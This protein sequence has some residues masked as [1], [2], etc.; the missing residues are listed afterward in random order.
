M[1]SES[2]TVARRLSKAGCA[3]LLVLPASLAMGAP[4]LAQSVINTSVTS[5]VSLDGQA[6]QVEIAAGVS[7]NASG[8]AAVSA[9]LPAQLSNNGQVVDSTGIGIALS[10]GGTVANGGVVSAGS[11]GVRVTGAG[12][13]VSNNGQ[14][15]A[16]YDG[17]S[18]NQGGSV[19]NSGSIFGGHIGVYTGNGL[20]V[21]QNSG[22][23][24]ARSGDAVSLYSGGT[25]T[26]TASGA[27]LGGYSG[28]YAGGNGASISNAGLISGPL[29]GV[30][31]MGDSTITNSGTIAGGTAGVIDIGRGGTVVNSGVIHGGKAGLQFAAGGGLD[32]AG[33]ISGGVDGVKLGKTGT[34]TNEAGGGITGGGVGV[35]AG[36]GDVILNQG[37]ITG[38]TGLQVNGAAS[39]E[40]AGIIA[41]SAGGD[42]ISLGGGAS[43]ITLDTGAEIDGDIAGNGTASFVSLTGH[44]SLAASI[45]GFQAGQLTVQQNA[46]W[47][48][49]G[50]WAVGQVVN[51]GTLTA[52]LVG[53]PLTITGDFTQTSTGTLRVVATPQGMNHLI[54]S[55]TAHLAG[56]L[57]YVLSP[58]TYAPASYKF[59]T[60]SAIS[61]DFATVETSDAAQ[62]S[63]LPGGSAAPATT[64]S[65]TVA[66]TPAAPSGG[67]AP[68]G[69]STVSAALSITQ[70]LVVVPK[71]GGLFADA[72]QAMALAGHA[73]G[74][75]LLAAGQ[76]AGRGGCSGPAPQTVGQAGNV[77]AALAD[78]LCRMGGWLQVTGSDLSTDGVYDARGGGFLAGLDRIV[79]A[80]RIGL[81]VGFDSAS[82]KDEAGGQASLQT[83]RLGLYG[84]L[85]AGP[86]VL[87]AALMDGLVTTTS[88]RATGAGGGAAS[89]NGNVLSA[90]LQAALPVSAWGAALR[91]AAGLEITR[92]SLGALSES[93][94][95]QALAVR[96]QA[97][98]GVYVAPYLRLSVSRRF[99][100]ARGLEIVPDAMLG[101]TV[102]ATNPGVSVA[103]TAR[104]GTAFIAAPLHLSPVSGEAGLGLS[105]GHGNW[106]LSARYDAILA[107]SFHAQS[108][109]ASL[110]VRF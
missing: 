62:H 82:L 96:T 76:G 89:G 1:K 68:T 105:I 31:L 109:Q 52:G 54:V 25:L 93:A 110:L 45:T 77:A 21:V 67:G 3:P 74:Q 78:G 6:G 58:G 23:I 91:P 53:M 103:M 63:R 75:T 50:T 12:G 92:V 33:R 38:Q 88:T 70:T 83:V 64:A 86:A 48:V 104:D 100:T 84:N 56:T 18:L 8:G 30:Y 85:P 57:A 9:G 65:V 19:S 80:G 55:G 94:A 37:T 108:L 35:L 81:A 20:G 43:R 42:A 66:T 71:D 73:A 13:T 90:V 29:F 27:L 41:A 7:I 24:S 99:I 61:G 106:R 14:I 97:A 39:I 59:L 72:G 36:A 15:G 46:V 34:L 47:T 95:N 51:A 40:S 107:R 16:G 69:A 102:N 4:A 44:G 28:V 49:S 32:N 5:G 11:Y 87:S 2:Q 60:A 79:G 26:N 17:V 98:H 10:Q 22:T 101:L